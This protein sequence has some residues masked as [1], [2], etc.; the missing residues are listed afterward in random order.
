MSAVLDVRGVRLGEGAPKLIVPVAGKELA[1][2]A[3]GAALAMDAGAEM[4]E[5][6]ADFFAAVSDETAL[7]SALSLLRQSIGETP[8]LFTL[9]SEGE[10]GICALSAIERAE[11]LLRAVNTG[12]AD[13]IDVEYSLSPSLVTKVVNGVRAA[14][15]EA[16]C[17][18]HDYKGTPSRDALVSL[19]KAMCASGARAVKLAVTAKDASDLAALFAAALRM[20]EECPACALLFMGLGEAGIFS[21]LAGEA[22]GSAAVFAAAGVKTDAGQL[23]ARSVAQNLSLFHTTLTEAYAAG[24]KRITP[25]TKLFGFFG[26]PLKQAY[27]PRILNELFAFHGLNFFYFPIEIPEE[28]FPAVLRGARAASLAG[29]SVTKPHKLAVL[30]YLDALGPSAAHAGACNTVVN[31]NGKWIGHNTDGIAGVEALRREGGMRIK[32]EAFLCIGAGGTARAMCYELALAGARRIYISS[33]SD[34]CQKVAAQFNEDFPGVFFPMRAEEE[35]LARC[36]ANCDAILNLSGSGMEPHT[37][38]TPFPK[39]AFLPRHLC[40]DAVYNPSPTRFLREAG[41]AGCK[42]I[43]GLGMVR[44]TAERQLGLWTQKR[45]RTENI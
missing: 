13:L 37:E 12:L 15:K 30:P 27:S 39:A 10:G 23:S 24:L 42:M 5:W 16:L 43:D 2:L 3:R 32:D 31:E 34:A 14:G 36:A 35:A 21:R 1:E 44:Y 38:E 45:E 4:I 20:K 11:L 28:E 41:E 7:F 17:S 26:I 8:L 18:L 25:E 29:F 9:R 6:R 19:M 40:F 33:R 22:F